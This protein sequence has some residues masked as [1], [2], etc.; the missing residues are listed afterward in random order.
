MFGWL[1]KMWNGL[2][3]NTQ[4]AGTPQQG[5]QAFQGL[6][7]AQDVQAQRQEIP[8]DADQTPA[9]EDGSEEE[10]GHQALREILMADAQVQT[11]EIQKIDAGVQTEKPL[12]EAERAVRAHRRGIRADKSMKMGG[13]H[14][15]LVPSNRFAVLLEDSEDNE[16][17]GEPEIHEGRKNTGAET[18]NLQE[19][20]DIGAGTEEQPPAPD[21]TEIRNRIQN[22]RQAQLWGNSFD[23]VNQGVRHF[24]D[25][26]DW[27]PNRIPAIA[28][29]LGQPGSF[30]YSLEGF[31]NFTSAAQNVIREAQGSGTCKVKNGKGIYYAAGRVNPDKGVIVIRV[32]GRLQSMMPADRHSFERME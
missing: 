2:W 11:E 21:K 10:H 1:K 17:D 14:P 24:C 31:M 16:E 12:P 26:W 5:Q 28:E 22:S 23:H 8:A 20:E 7:I 32:G 3:G 29:R 30:S 9:V 13:S 18:E 27:Y 4:E 19:R 6:G 25:Y 15:M